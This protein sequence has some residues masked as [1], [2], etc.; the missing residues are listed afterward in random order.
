MCFSATASFGASIVLGVT[1]V[2]TIRSVKNPSQFAFASIPLVFAVQQSIEGI[3]WLSLSHPDLGKYEQAASLAYLIIAQV[4]WSVFLPTAFLLFEKNPNR[5]KLIRPFLVPGIIVAV[6]FL[7]CLFSFQMVTS[8]T[9]HHIFYNLDF[10]RKLV[11]FAAAFYLIATVIPPF[12]SKDIRIKL[13]GI[14]LL[15]SYIVARIFFQPSLISVWCFFAIVIG[16]LVYLVMRDK[17]Q[18]SGSSETVMK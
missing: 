14:V 15:A 3:V 4:V 8:N 2:A 7:Y 6:Y 12:L 18:L 11:P 10:P 17:N 5:K 9:D 13:I 16:I 1:S